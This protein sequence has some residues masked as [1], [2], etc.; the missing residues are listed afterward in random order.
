MSYIF[1]ERF[2]ARE[3]EKTQGKCR[4]NAQRGAHSYFQCTCIVAEY[5]CVDKK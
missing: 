3:W 4:K 5:V 1:L 2:Y